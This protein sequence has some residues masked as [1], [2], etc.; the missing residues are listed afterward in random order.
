MSGQYYL[1]YFGFTKCPDICPTTLHYLT[2]VQ[3]YLRSFPEAHDTPLKIVFVSVDPQRDEPDTLKQYLSNFKGE[4]IGV[5]GRSQEDE[6]LRSCMKKFKIYANRVE[7]ASGYNMDHTTMVYLLDGSSRY[8]D[9]VNP[10]QSERDTAL[11]LL[12][13]IR[14]HRAS[15]GQR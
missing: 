8:V 7:T 2:T 5:T 10:S 9:H 12:A 15:Q 4:V 13:R 11:Q 14:Q 3:T 6:S 1:I